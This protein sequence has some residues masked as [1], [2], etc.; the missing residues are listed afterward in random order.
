MV[1]A[2]IHMQLEPVIGAIA[3]DDNLDGSMLAAFA[4]RAQIAAVLR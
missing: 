1:P 3:T 4:D 2:K